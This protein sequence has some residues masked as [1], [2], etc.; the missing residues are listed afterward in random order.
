VASTWASGPRRGREIGR[1]DGVGAPVAGAGSLFGSTIA[2]SFP[3]A[4]AAV[5]PGWLKRLMFAAGD[6]YIIDRA[7]GAMLNA[8]RAELGLAAD[9]RNPARLAAFAA[10]DDRLFPEWFAPIQPEWRM[11]RSV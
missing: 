2:D 8:F 10:I 1:G 5:M 4:V 7:A 9:L 6:R 3:R 11:A